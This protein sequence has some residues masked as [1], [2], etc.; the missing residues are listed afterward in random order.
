MNFRDTSELHVRAE[1]ALH[2]RRRT[3]TAKRVCRTGSYHYP[4]KNRNLD[5][6]FASE[7]TL[8]FD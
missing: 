5:Q 4:E 8:Q 6:G 2:H 1:H 3:T 7:D